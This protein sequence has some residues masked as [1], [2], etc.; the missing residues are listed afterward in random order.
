M[1]LSNGPSANDPLMATLQAILLAHEREQIEEL[2]RKLHLLQ[3][4]VNSGLLALE[5]REREI[6]AVLE[7]VRRLANDNQF[8]SQQLQAEIALLQRRARVDSEGLIAQLAPVLGD[9]IGR[10]IRDSRDEMADALGPVMG[11]AIRVQ[12]RDS[13][14]DMIDALYP[15]IGST[16]QRAVTESVGEIQRNVDARLRATFG[17]EGIWRAIGARMRGVSPSELALRDALPFR[18]RQIFLIQQQSGLLLARAGDEETAD[19]DLI[20]A[21]LTAI[22]DFVHDS[23]GPDQDDQLD[24]VRYGQQR[25]V[26]QSGPDVYL[27]I[28][29]SGIE[30]EGFHNQLRHFVSELHVNHGPGL[31]TYNGDPATLPNVQPKLSRLLTDLS[32][33]TSRPRSPRTRR[34]KVALAGL[35]FIG[36]LFLGLACFYLQFTIA[37]VPVAFPSATPTNTATATNTPTPTPTATPT[38]T[39]TPTPTHTPTS[40]YTPT[41]TQTATPTATPTPTPTSTA[42]PTD[43]PTPTNTPTPPAAVTTGPVWVRLQ[44]ATEAPLVLALEE[45]AAL[46]VY[47]V[48]GPWAWV[49][50]FD[51]PSI[52]E[53]G[54]RRGWIPLLV[55]Q[56]NTPIPE[57]FVT[58]FP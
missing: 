29:Y 35:G 10:K 22:R 20:S 11:E 23:F 2:K 21:M 54:Q 7:T 41:N 15:V 47:A 12:I 14:D 42:T 26:V 8:F 51:A 44:P 16:V 4:D 57:G 3:Q 38:N 13:R 50:W 52:V 55:V 25:I 31:R 33:E 32:G 49:E 5:Q 37:L 56:A 43:T 18:I 19:S 24:Q 39:P 30:P 48:Y 53:T 17:R 1:D 58:P 40:T 46:V 34:Q 27:A 6:T 36:L 45:N 9:L 28:V